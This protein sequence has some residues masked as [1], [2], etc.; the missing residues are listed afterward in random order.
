MTPVLFGVGVF[1]V[2]VIAGL[3]IGA[4]AVIMDR[5]VNADRLVIAVI[6]LVVGAVA[7]LGA[8]GAFMAAIIP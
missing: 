6:I 5:V 7:L 3:W 8:F 1:A 2:I 4:L